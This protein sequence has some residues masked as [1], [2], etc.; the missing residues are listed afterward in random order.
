MGFKTQTILVRPGVLDGGPDKFLADLGYDKR[1][2]VDDT[3]FCRAERAAS[4]SARSAIALLSTRCWRGTSSM[5]PRQMIRYFT[6]FKNALFRHF[7]GADIAALSLHNVIDAWGFA[8]FRRGS[9]IR[10]QHGYD[11]SIL[12]DEGPRLPA[13]DV[14]LSKFERI[15]LRARSSTGILFIQNTRP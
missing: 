14:C 5:T 13:E 1:R 9:L 12:C 2:K 11:G 4:G 10:R 8:V 7:P 6:F 3:P 15:E